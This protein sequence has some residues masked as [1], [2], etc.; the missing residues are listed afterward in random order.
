MI[1]SRSV[2]ISRD[3][4]CVA[5]HASADTVGGSGTAEPH[6]K[7]IANYHVRRLYFDLNRLLEN[8]M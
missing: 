1:Q 6:G 3:V 4:E 8:S 5:C 2:R 7:H